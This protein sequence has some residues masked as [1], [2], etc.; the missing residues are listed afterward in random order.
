[1]T[2]LDVG[3]SEPTVAESDL[4]RA[5]ARVLRRWPSAGIAVSVVREGSPPRFLGHGVADT[6]SGRP[7]SEQTV[8]R[9]GSLTKVLTAVAVMQL[10]EQGRVDLDAPAADY[11]RAFQL[12][13]TETDFQPATVRQ[14]LT[15]SAGLGY[16]RRRSDLLLHPGVGSGDMARSVVPLAQYY[17]DGLPRRRA[18]GDE[19][20]LQQPRF[21]RP[22][23][24]RGGPLR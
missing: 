15:H 10:L 7:I 8:F 1:M 22:R 18:A 2:T 14:L 4:H 20:G 13:P 17:R 12:V 16:W 5:I 11:L 24:D 21:R 19:V 9:V 3:H 6:A 23:A